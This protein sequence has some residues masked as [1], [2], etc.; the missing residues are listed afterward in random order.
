M[1]VRDGAFGSVRTR[2]L[3]VGNPLP[4]EALE[5]RRVLSGEALSFD[6]SEIPLGQTV[7]APPTSAAAAADI[8]LG[9]VATG[10]NMPVF[11]TYAPGDADGLYIPE[12]TTGNI[13][14][15]D[16]KTSTVGATPFL[17]ASGIITGG[18]AGLLGLAF[19]PDYAK[20][21][22][23][24]V[25]IVNESGTPQVDEYR[26]SSTN[27]EIADPSTRHKIL[28]MRGPHPIKHFGGWMGFGKDLFLYIA[29][30]D[31]GD[32]DPGADASLVAPG[33]AQIIKDNLYGS[34]LR[35]DPLQDAFPEDANRNYAIPADNPLVNAV[36]DDEIWAYGLRNPWRVSFD[37]LTGDMYLGDV[38]QNT[39]EEIN[40]I[41]STARSGMNFGWPLREGTISRPNSAFGGLKPANAVDPVYEFKTGT[42]DDSQG[43]SVTGGYVYRGPIQELN[44]TYFF[45][46]FVRSRVWS[47]KTTATDPAEF[48]GNNSTDYTDWTSQ[49][50]S[51]I[52]G[53]S[54]L[55]SFGEDS[56]GN[57]YVVNLLGSIHRL[58]GP[59]ASQKVFRTYNP[60]ADLHFFTTRSSEFYA[61]IE[62]GY[63]DES[64]SP[65]FRSLVLP[66][67]NT[68]PL[69]R[70]YNPNTGAHYLTI[71]SGERDFLVSAGWNAEGEMGYLYKS[72]RA[73]ALEVFRLYNT[74]SGIHLFTTDPTERDTILSTFGEIW[75]QHSSLGFA[76]QDIS[77]PP[78]VS[79][80]RTTLPV[81][82]GLATPEEDSPEVSASTLLLPGL[83]T[84]WSPSPT[85]AAN[86]SSPP[87]PEPSD[88][89]A[90]RLIRLAP[91]EGLDNLF[92][93]LPEDLL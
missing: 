24:Y 40:L 47:I 79:S 25:F 83:I 55:V 46:D 5:I 61:V 72:A 20:D 43:R 10:L 41:P 36:G 53:V 3:T 77:T 76:P 38:G 89:S 80:A 8:A 28:E 73:G 39:R 45:G 29:V 34:I 91:V 32:T 9:T 1:P 74:N 17:T 66:D 33:N 56:Y 2:R 30:G 13:L 92:E 57:L 84:S 63:R 90:E 82:P 7:S 37:R 11:A 23:L 65:S 27:P 50:T 85:F 42:A 64:S 59:V 69:Y 14:R 26:R 54:Q 51:S 81:N 48:N 4:I 19:S 16:L 68:S 6:L 35:I 87:E 44:G 71:D 52:P 62:Q 78:V 21:G 67:I 86:P 18:E 15:I 12:L 49:L 60:N 58:T 93:Q 70:M 75:V 31:G 88:D 22:K